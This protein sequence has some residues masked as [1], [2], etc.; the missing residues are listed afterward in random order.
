MTH[1]NLCKFMFMMTL[2][3]NLMLVDVDNVLN[4][5]G[6]G[7]KLRTPFY[8]VKVSELIELVKKI[9]VNSKPRISR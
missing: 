2:M 4:D 1:H 5:Y 9:T 7:I 3:M 8:N 6:N